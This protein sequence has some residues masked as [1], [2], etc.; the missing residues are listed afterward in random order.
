[1]LAKQLNCLELVVDPCGHRIAFPEARQPPVPL[2]YL[3]LAGVSVCPVFDLVARH[4]GSD[5]KIVGQQPLPGVGGG[6]IWSGCRPGH[7]ESRV[8]SVI[9]ESRPAADECR[10][11]VPLDE[12]R[13]AA[14]PV[15]LEE[16]FE[17]VHRGYHAVDI[18]HNDRSG[19]GEWISPRR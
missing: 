15:A 17:A 16:P 1:M 10:F 6:V 19:V 12:L 9:D 4:D 13:P 18:A 14:E 2:A 11:G 5:R 3:H 8:D 7:L